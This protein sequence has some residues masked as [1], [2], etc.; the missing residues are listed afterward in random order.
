MTLQVSHGQGQLLGRVVPSV[1]TAVQ[2]FKAVEL[3]T[4]ITLLIAVQA[5]LGGANVADLVVFH[6]DSGS[7]VYNISTVV[8]ADRFD[9]TT[10]EGFGVALFQAQHP[11]SGITL[12]P[13]GSIGV[14]TSKINETVFTCYG[15]TETIA[16]RL[17]GIR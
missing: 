4:E 14:Q 3:R 10:A 11:G 9:R 8:L 17:R 7:D 12:S 15:V 5:P 1:I 13:G 2:L 16:E 6:D